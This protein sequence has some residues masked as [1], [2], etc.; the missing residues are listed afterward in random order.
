[1]DRVTEQSHPLSSPI[2]TG[3]WNSD[4]EMEITDDGHLP[5]EVEAANYRS[6][7]PRGSAVLIES[8]FARPKRI[9][10]NPR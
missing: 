6:D 9:H 8:R 7:R 3:D 1:M 4:N 5:R 2:A 10:G